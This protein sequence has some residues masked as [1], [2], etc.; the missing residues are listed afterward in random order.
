MICTAHPVL[1]GRS[2]KGEWDGRRTWWIW[3]RGAFDTA[4]WPEKTREGDH[5][6][7]LGADGS[8]ILKW[9]FNK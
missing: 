7:I 2:S 4:F 8:I 1:F 3:G 6:D 5:F 9:I